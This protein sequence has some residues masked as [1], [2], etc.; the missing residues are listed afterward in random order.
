MVFMS[1]VLFK[2][3]GR[4]WGNYKGGKLSG[5]ENICPLMGNHSHRP[6]V[7]RFEH[8]LKTRVDEL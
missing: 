5:G 1:K 6:A 2:Q 7:Y 4:E 3:I 8:V